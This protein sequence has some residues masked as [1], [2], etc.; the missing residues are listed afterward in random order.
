[1]V[2]GSVGSG[3]TSLLSAIL[4]EMTAI[5]GKVLF[6]EEP[7]KMAL[8]SQKAWI[9]NASLQDNVI[10]GRKMNCQ[11]YHKIV[12]ASGLDP[13]IVML[14]AG[15]QTEIGEKGIN[16]SGG[17]QQRVSIAR[18]LYSERDIVLLDDPLSAL[19]VHVGK[20]VFENGIIDGLRKEKK[21]VILVTHQ[22]QYLKEA[23][24]VCF[25]GYLTVKVAW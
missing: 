17:Q 14:P 24:Q 22:I 19:D 11:R 1:M 23:D 5:K 3:K 2:V 21:T 18:A 7:P 8:S 15:D 4:G 16:I 6:S 13:D 20:H 9:L 10:L 12:A 25:N